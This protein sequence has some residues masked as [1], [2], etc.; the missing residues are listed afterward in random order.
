MWGETSTI[1]IRLHNYYTLGYYIYAQL[2]GR[3][4]YNRPSIVLTD[5]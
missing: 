2:A 3:S 1:D 4:H 5:S